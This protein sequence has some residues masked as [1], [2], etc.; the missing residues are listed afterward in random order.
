MCRAVF[1]WIS[2][3]FLVF[4]SQASL[5][6]V[7][8]L[9]FFRLSVNKLIVEAEQNQSFAQFVLAM[10]YQVGFGVVQSHQKAAF[11][12]KRAAIAGN[13]EAQRLI[14][15]IHYNGLGVPKDYIEAYAWWNIA[16]IADRRKKFSQRE[17][18]A[19]RDMAEKQM[20]AQSVAKAQI[21]SQRLY[22]VIQRRQQRN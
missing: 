19:L 22:K 1:A 13:Y 15:E 16:S 17:V 11:W 4:F 7:D 14:G 21:R 9:P 20:S 10:R 6:N 2:C 12:Y 3:F 5:S 18:S 8:H